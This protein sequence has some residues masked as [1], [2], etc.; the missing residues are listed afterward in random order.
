MLSIFGDTPEGEALVFT[1][2]DLFGL[3]D[4]KLFSARQHHLIMKNFVGTEADTLDFKKKTLLP[5]NILTV[6]Y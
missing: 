5:L 6:P 4:L 2:V 1:G 3:Q